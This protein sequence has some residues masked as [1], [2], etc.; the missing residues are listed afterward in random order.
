MEKIIHRYFEAVNSDSVDSLMDLWNEEC[1]FSMPFRPTMKDKAE[2]RKFY[3]SLPVIYPEHRDDPIDFIVGE[4][5]A[6]VK[7]VV[8]NKTVDGKTVLFNAFSWMTF[9]NGKIKSLESIFDSAKLMQ[10][11]KG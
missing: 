7:I 9:Q 1:E 11:L 6:A 10:D 2:I 3:E 4:N 8:K 5:K